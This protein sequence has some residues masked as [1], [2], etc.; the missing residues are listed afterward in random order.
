LFI[1]PNAPSKKLKL[2]VARIFSSAAE[3]LCLIGRNILP[4]AGNTA[5]FVKTCQLK[6]FCISGFEKAMQEVFVPLSSIFLKLVSYLLRMPL[7]VTNMKEGATFCI[8]F[9]YSLFLLA[10]TQRLDRS[11]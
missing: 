11:L 9:R 2:Q 5:P 7:R 10:L 1:K 6:L 8:Y 3:F 4:R